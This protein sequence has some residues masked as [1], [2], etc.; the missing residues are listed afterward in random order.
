MLYFSHTNET[1]KENIMTKAAQYF[2][3]AGNEWALPDEANVLAIFEFAALVGIENKWVKLRADVQKKLFGFAVFG[4]RDVMI[5]DMG[6]VHMFTPNG[7]GFDG[8]THIFDIT[9]LKE[10]FDAGI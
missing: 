6:E 2:E 8:D 3:I 9:R 5:T 1:L 7:F 4:K 10:L